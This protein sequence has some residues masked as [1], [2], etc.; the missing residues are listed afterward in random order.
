MRSDSEVQPLTRVAFE[1]SDFAPAGVRTVLSFASRDD[2]QRAIGERRLERHRL[3][4]RRSEPK[5][6]L[7][8]ARQDPGIAFG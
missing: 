3:F 2:P 5:V 1:I 6:D 8:A 4:C 7:V